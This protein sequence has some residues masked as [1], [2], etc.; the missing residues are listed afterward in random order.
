MQRALTRPDARVGI[1]TEYTLQLAEHHGVGLE[2][3]FGVLFH[4]ARE[5][6][7]PRGGDALGVAMRHPRARPEQR[8]RQRDGKAYAYPQPQERSRGGFFLGHPPPESLASGCCS[9]WSPETKFAGSWRASRRDPATATRPVCDSRRR[10]AHRARGA[11]D[12][13]SGDRSKCAP[14]PPG[15]R[16][17][18]LHIP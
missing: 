18:R 9:S 6:I 2:R 12:P 16:R 7:E 14:A 8:E 17:R 10:K 1:V 5:V 3:S 13:G 4:Y 15:I 11:R